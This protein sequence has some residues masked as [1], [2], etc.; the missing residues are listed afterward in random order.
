MLIHSSQVLVCLGDLDRA[1]SQRETALAE[2]RRLSHPHTLAAALSF[3]SITGGCVGAD[4]KSLCQCADEDVTLST[5]HGFAYWR[6]IGLISSGWCRT[7]LGNADEGL[8]LLTT[9]FAGIVETGL[10]FHRPWGLTL[11][12]DACRMAGEVE[13]ALGHLAEAHR[14]AEETQNRWVHAETL[15]L[16]GEVLLAMD[17]PAAAEASYREAIGLALRQRAKL[18]ELRATMSL[19]RLWRDQRKC[20]EAR[21]LLSAVYGSFTVGFG[22]PV[23]QEAKT[24]LDKLA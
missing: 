9:G 6:A 11:F 19:A 2:A 7:A 24:L 4:P 1:L 15:R 14:L 12:A 18:W 17:D 22:T 3:A 8:A 20:T 5:E 13:A 23:M 10:M 16:R 21:D